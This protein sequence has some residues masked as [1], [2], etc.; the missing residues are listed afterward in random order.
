VSRGSPDREAPAVK[1]DG[2]LLVF[3][4]A[5][6]CKQFLDQ[7]IN[8]LLWIRVLISLIRFTRV[9]AV[10]RNHDEGS[11]SRLCAV[12]TLSE[13][14]KYH[15]YAR[16]CLRLAEAADR[17]D[18]REKLVEL[19]RVWIEA[20]LREARHALAML[21]GMASKTAASSRSTLSS[22]GDTHWG[23]KLGGTRHLSKKP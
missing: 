6:R 7:V 23:K 15:V 2:S 1:L 14:E 22:S 11:W 19:S 16:E 5:E 8:T 21:E 10:S 18:D 13:A 12:M 17:S 3:L 4:A 9:N 20:A